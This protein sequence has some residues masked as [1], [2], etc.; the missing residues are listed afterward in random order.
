MAWCCRS[1]TVS[2]PVRAGRIVFAEMPPDLRARPTLVTKIDSD[3]AGRVSG[4]ARLSDRRPLLGGGLRRRALARREQH[5]AQG[6]GDADQHQRH[7]LSQ[8]PAAARRR[9]R[10]PGA[11]LSQMKQK[12]RDARG[13][14]GRADAGAG[15]VRISPLYA[16]PADHH[17]RQPDQ[18]GGAADGP[19]HSGDQGI[20]LRPAWANPSTTR[21]GER[22]AGQCHGA[23]QLRQRRE[24]EAGH[25]AAQG[26]RARLQGRQPARRCS[27]ARTRSI[28]RRRT[29]W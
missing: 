20:P 18:A 15:A 3:K 11:T 28:T 16:G 7:D 12:A 10:Q 1:A 27:S 24:H 26:H 13:S 14:S 29:R 9:Q 23:A 22:A 8:R 21:C 6:L 2:R 19:R 4:R 25:A 5:R 17:R